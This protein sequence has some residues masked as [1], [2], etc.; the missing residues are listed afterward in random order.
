MITYNYDTHCR[1]ANHDIVKYLVFVILLIILGLAISF[2]LGYNNMKSRYLGP[3]IFNSSVMVVHTLLNQESLIYKFGYL[4]YESIKN[5]VIEH[6]N[7][8]RKHGEKIAYI[9]ALELVLGEIS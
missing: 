1:V 4:R 7:G 6:L 9:M 2:S 3:F 5:M 8:N